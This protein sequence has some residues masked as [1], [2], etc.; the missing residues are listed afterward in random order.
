MATLW[1]FG[2]S[3]S[4]PFS[5]NPYKL[6]G[7]YLKFKGYVP[8]I[9]SEIVAE[10][11]NLNC[12]IHAK[13]GL[14]NYSILE[15]V[16]KISDKVGEDDILIIGW[17]DVCRFRLGDFDNDWISILP[18]YIPKELSNLN[19]DFLDYFLVNRYDNRKKYTEEVNLWIKLINRSF[20]NNIVVNWSPFN[21]E[22]LNVKNFRKLSSIREESGNLIDD[23]HYGEIGHQMLA[24][25]FLNLIKKRKNKDLI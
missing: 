23:G 4:T 6:C 1:S 12:S 20:K 8:K 19:W 14:D 21:Q 2:D 17:S 11:L 16:C 5:K 15:S 3:F 13:G 18:N 10:K 24:D 7:D 9:F 22:N 25:I